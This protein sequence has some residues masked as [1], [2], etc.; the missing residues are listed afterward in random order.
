MA[1]WKLSGYDT[2]AHEDYPLRGS[3]ASQKAAERA[4]RRRLGVLEM[5]QPSHVSGGQAG[6]QDRVY[7]HGPDGTSYCFEP[8]DPV[9]PGFF[10]RLAWKL[11][12]LDM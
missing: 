11:G 1:R 6:L 7:V 12:L 9:R 10:M 2:F 5:M 8:P 4:A 3:Y